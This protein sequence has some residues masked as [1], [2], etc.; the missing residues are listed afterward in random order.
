MI[1][2]MSSIRSPFSSFVVR[3]QNCKQAFTSNNDEKYPSLKEEK[4][5][6]K[7]TMQDWEKAHPHALQGDYE[8]EAQKRY[9]RGDYGKV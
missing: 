1:S 6:V 3:K 9:A 4:Q 7:G 5:E 8:R 2:Q